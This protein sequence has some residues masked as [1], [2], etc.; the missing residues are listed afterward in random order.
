MSSFLVVF[1][2]AL[3]ALVAGFQ[4]GTQRLRVAS[5]VQTNYLKRNNYQHTRIFAGGNNDENKRK[6]VKYD[7]LGGKYN[8]FRCTIP[9]SFLTYSFLSKI[10]SMKMRSMLVTALR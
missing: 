7:N 5:G 4:T 2:L 3:L 9:F 6:I 8:L 10:Q 1:F